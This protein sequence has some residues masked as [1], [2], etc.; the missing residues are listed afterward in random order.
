MKMLGDDIGLLV[1]GGI[2]GHPQ[3]TRSG[4]KAAM[5]AIEAA[6][7]EI[8]LQTYAKTHLELKQSLDKW[9]F[10]KPK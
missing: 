9:G 8:P 4:A 6:M 2:H 10:R 7:Q 1:S 3:G 5:Q